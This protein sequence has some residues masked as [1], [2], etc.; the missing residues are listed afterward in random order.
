MKNVN[1]QSKY[2]SIDITYTAPFHYSEEHGF[3]HFWLTFLGVN[4]T[5][6]PMHFLGLSG[7]PR[8][9]PDFPDAYSFWNL[10]SSFGSLLTLLGIIFLVLSVFIYPIMDRINLNFP[11]TG[12]NKSK[13]NFKFNYELIS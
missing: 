1:F 11:I 2:N 10:V 6:F 5:F 9:I 3:T 7:M 8:R 4:L 13:K 12:F